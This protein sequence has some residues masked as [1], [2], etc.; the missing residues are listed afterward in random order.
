VISKRRYCL[1]PVSIYFWFG[2][3]GKVMI[4]PLHLSFFI[5]KMKLNPKLSLGPGSEN[6]WGEST[7]REKTFLPQSLL[8]SLLTFT[9]GRD[10]GALQNAH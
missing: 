10:N 1:N 8:G 3:P 2:G 9:C 4:I 5:Y 6:S 7:T